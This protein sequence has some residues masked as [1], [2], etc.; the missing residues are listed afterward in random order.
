M[1]LRQEEYFW[2]EEVVAQQPTRVKT[3]TNKKNNFKRK[4]FFGVVTFSVAL[5][6][7]ETIFFLSFL[8]LVQF[9]FLWI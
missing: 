2:E 9:A 7:S 4:V 6:T 3:K 1:P 5:V 8:I